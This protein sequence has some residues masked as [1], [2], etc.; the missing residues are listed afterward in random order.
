MNTTRNI[1][2]QYDVTLYGH[3]GA[4]TCRS[5]GQAEN[6]ARTLI[7]DGYDVSIGGTVFEVQS[8]D[9]SPATIGP[10]N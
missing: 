2:D 10:R 4:I 9:T 3:D 6:L 1:S 7:L 8:W 5:F